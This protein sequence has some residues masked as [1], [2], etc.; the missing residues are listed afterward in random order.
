MKAVRYTA[1][2]V[3]TRRTARRILKPYAKLLATVINEAWTTWNRFGA[4]APDVRMQ[5]GR[6]SRAFNISDFIKEAIVRRFRDVR[7]CEVVMEYGRPVLVLG[8]G[9]LK[10]RLGKINPDAVPRPQS[11]RQWGIWR[12]D[13]AMACTLP[14]MPS[15]TWAKCGYV[16]DDTETGLAS[17]SVT[18]DVEGTQVWILHLP[19][20][21]SRVDGTVTPLASSTVPP[22]R[23]SSANLPS[24]A[25]TEAA[26]SD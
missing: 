24:T 22:A 8:G 13:E 6:S 21:M 14:G 17:I 19:I 15:A 18:C 26:S 23:I 5:L 7:G 3:L 16:L 9:D 2:G 11:E 25:D 12:Q 1:H 10:L 4:S 20:P